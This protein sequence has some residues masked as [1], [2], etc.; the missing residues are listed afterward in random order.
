[1]KFSRVIYSIIVDWWQKGHQKWQD[2]QKQK[3]LQ[4]LHTQATQ[5]SYKLVDEL[6]M[7]FRGRSYLGML[8]TKSI[9]D[10]RFQRYY[11]L[12][13]KRIMYLFTCTKAIACDLSASD[14]KLIKQQMNQDIIKFKEDV[15]FQEGEEILAGFFP[16][17]YWGACVARVSN[18][19]R[20]ERE[21]LLYII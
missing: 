15:Y 10:L 1:M 18:S 3:Q 21:L 11:I 16:C 2:E 20:S 8:F 5:N 19:P 9:P 17:L 6:S 14:L 12:E 4:E 13:N 7:A